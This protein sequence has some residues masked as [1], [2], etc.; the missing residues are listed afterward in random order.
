LSIQLGCLDLRFEGGGCEKVTE[1]QNNENGA[2]FFI[3][4]I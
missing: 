4:L 2:T 1:K 3:P